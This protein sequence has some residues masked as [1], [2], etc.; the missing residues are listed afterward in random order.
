MVLVGLQVVQLWSATQGM[1]ALQRPFVTQY[2]LMSRSDVG[3][4]LADL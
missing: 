4:Q 3:P 1:H 2:V